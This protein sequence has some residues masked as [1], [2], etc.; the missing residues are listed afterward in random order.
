MDPVKP[1]PRV[2]HLFVS[3]KEHVTVG[4]L[5]SETGNG[6]DGSHNGQ[7][8]VG[9]NRGAG[10]GSTGWSSS[11]VEMEILGVVMEWRSGNGVGNGHAV[12]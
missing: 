1:A 2:N 8:G 10:R 11:G 7:G 5:I 4:G 6:V 3:L 9:G 12:T